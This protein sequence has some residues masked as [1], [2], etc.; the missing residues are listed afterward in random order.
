MSIAPAIQIEQLPQT[1]KQ[2]PA[3]A[4]IFA[5]EGDSTL[6]IKECLNN[7]RAQGPASR[8]NIWLIVGS[9]GGFSYQ[10]VEFLKQTGLEPVTIGRQVLRVETACIALVAALK[11]EFDLMKS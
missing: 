4:G 3:A 1:I 8:Q 10:E 7:M 11:Y 5:Y 9:E 2:D 6:S